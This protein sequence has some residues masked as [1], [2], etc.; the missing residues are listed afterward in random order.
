VGQVPDVPDLP[1]VGI[2][3][4]ARNRRGNFYCPLTYVLPMKNSRLGSVLDMLDAL[5]LPMELLGFLH[6]ALLSMAALIC[7]YLWLRSN[8]H[9]TGSNSAPVRAFPNTAGDSLQP[10]RT[11]TRP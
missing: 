1:C 5:D 9:P 11:P 4:G 7:L 3:A 6:P 10:D 2:H 8:P